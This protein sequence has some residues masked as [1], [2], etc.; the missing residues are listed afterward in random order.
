MGGCKND[1]ESQNALQPR[2]GWSE[3]CW[4]SFSSSGERKSFFECNN[5]K[6]RVFL[7]SL[8]LFLNLWV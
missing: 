5:R 8:V 4:E 7:G 3:A 1:Y 2:P 6:L